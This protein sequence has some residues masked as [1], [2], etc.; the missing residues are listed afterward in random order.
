MP[1]KGTE[2]KATQS[3]GSPRTRILSGA[4]II[5]S[6]LLLA[7]LLFG[8][9]Y[10]YFTARSTKEVKA[11]L[12]SYEWSWNSAKEQ[13]RIEAK[14]RWKLDDSTGTY[15]DTQYNSPSSRSR[16]PKSTFAQQGKE[17]DP[18]EVRPSSSVTLRAY[19][20]SD[21]AWKI[22]SHSTTSDIIYVV[23]GYIAV[24]CLGAWL[25]L[26]GIMLSRRI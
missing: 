6:F 20:K 21:G 9:Y 24:L 8:D 13:Y 22:A 26:S 1:R 5:T 12:E 11:V 19:Q 18:A 16:V 2:A 10:E 17:S 23:S 15:F 14:Y 7:P 4:A 25:A 3:K